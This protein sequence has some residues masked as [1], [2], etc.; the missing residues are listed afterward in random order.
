M[1]LTAI[2]YKENLS[3]SARRD[4]LRY[5][6]LE[7]EI[8]LF[9]EENPIEEEKREKKWEEILDLGQLPIDIPKDWVFIDLPPWIQYLLW[10]NLVSKVEEDPNLDITFQ[11]WQKFLE[12][13]YR[14]SLIQKFALLRPGGDFFVCLAYEYLNVPLPE[15]HGEL[16]LTFIEQLI[17]SRGSL[18]FR[19][20]RRASLPEEATRALIRALA[21]DVSRSYN[22]TSFEEDVKSVLHG[23]RQTVANKIWGPRSGGGRPTFRAVPAL[24][25]MYGEE[26]ASS[27]E[28]PFVSMRM[29]LEMSRD[30]PSLKLKA[31]KRVFKYDPGGDRW[32]QLG[33]LN[34]TRLF[35]G[36]ADQWIQKNVKEGRSVHDAVY[37]LPQEDDK[38][39][40]SLLWDGLKRAK[41][42]SDM[43]TLCSSWKDLSEDEK[44]LGFNEI[45][46]L[47]RGRIYPNHKDAAFA[48]EAARWAVSK[49]SYPELESRYIR[50]LTQPDFYP[51][52]KVEYK[53]LK[54]YFLRRNDPRG[55]FL[56]QHT[57]CCQHPFGAGKA[58]AWYGQEQ[59][60]SGFFVVEDKGAII[61]QSW[62][63]ENDDEGICFDNV[64]AKSLGDR[65]PKVFRVYEEAARQL[66]ENNSFKAITAGRGANDLP[67]LDGEPESEVQ[68]DPPKDFS[69]HTD[70][71]NQFSFFT[72]P[73]WEGGEDPEYFISGL[74][75]DELENCEE[76]AA[77]VY[78]EGWQFAGS[79]E[80]DCGFAIWVLE[81]EMYN[82]VGYA[83]IE[84]QN[85]YISDMAVLPEYRKYSLPLIRKVLD[86]C[87][88]FD[89]E[90]EVDARESTSY[91]LLKLMDRR[92]R[93]TLLSEEESEETIAGERM[94]KVRFSC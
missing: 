46:K 63:W 93:L 23:G 83:T 74:L 29:A 44:E 40:A 82:L 6:E 55:L 21:E 85:R 92:G 47:V 19:L 81:E 28:E 43:D 34:A 89:G 48:Q 37:F 51:E 15:I 54:G 13:F 20:G 65:S 76:V 73:D 49:D 16:P 69:G 80:S 41:A 24:R 26:V 79:E 77:Q 12:D 68:L 87:S 10:S 64:E 32:I 36:Q 61:A 58:C 1:S 45:L 52:V 2:R 78:P 17:E 4:S 50:S 53:G 86:F 33:L 25:M 91:R 62:T 35:G 11:E 57:D 90:W 14:G 60:N 3:L 8:Q 38:R 94:I 84:S 75:E 72:N 42:T 18:A 59:E 56:G 66:W 67:E 27:K 71:D 31:L 30:L 70:C 39:L 88:R 9:F 5:H 7:D 22:W